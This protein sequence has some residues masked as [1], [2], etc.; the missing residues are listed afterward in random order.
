MRRG[1]S[2]PWA[3]VPHIS[4]PPAL[5][6][7]LAIG[8]TH[9]RAV[10]L[11]TATVLASG[12][13]AYAV[14][15]GSLGATLAHGVSGFGAADK[16][17]LWLAAAGFA[18]S[19][20]ATAA[21]WRSTVNS[22]GARMSHVDAWARYGVGSIIN[23]FLPARLGD[24]ARVGLFS[25]ALPRQQSG[26]ALTAV[27]ALGAVSIAEALTQAPIVAAAAGLGVVPFW[28]I[29]VV[30]G[31]AAGA[32]G[33]AFVAGRR[34]RGGRLRQLAAAF[35]SLA[36]SPRQA[37][38][39]FAW[40]GAATAARVLAAAA[41]AAAVGVAN[42][43]EAGLIMS[44]VLSLAT[45][46]PLTPGNVGV[47]SAAIVLALHA[48]G[49]PLA[50]AIAAGVAFH[51]VEAAAGI[52]FGAGGAVYLTR[53]RSTAARIWSLRIAGAIAGLMLVASVGATTLPALV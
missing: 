26:Q 9:R 3:A 11:A 32:A 39:L 13:L 15:S 45:A 22:C 46:I 16:R 29:L 47:T 7:G 27:G 53:Y 48:R 35:R 37:V 24:A 21:A 50:S 34:L 12:G 14:D 49:V 38:R 19:L 30:L 44:A 43:L 18:A 2:L 1:V 8:G 23:T 31:L 17:W 28:S 25:R 36:A 10:A 6:T 52:A 42:P 5:H 41:I 4:T 33:L 40:S 51:A 20:L